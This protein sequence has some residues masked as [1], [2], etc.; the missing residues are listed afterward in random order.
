MDCFISASGDDL[1]HNRSAIQKSDWSSYYVAGKAV[2]GNLNSYSCTTTSVNY[3]YWSVDLG[4]STYV[5]HLYI[6]NVDD[7]NGKFGLVDNLVRYRRQAITW[8]RQ[9]LSSRLHTWISSPFKVIQ[10]R[11]CCLRDIINYFDWIS[12]I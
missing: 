11:M 6:T 9:W 1:A 12:L 10:M 5:D 4:M 2:D 3:P 7:R 8:K